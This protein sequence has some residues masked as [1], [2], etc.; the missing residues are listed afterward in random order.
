MLSRPW[1]VCSDAG[2]FGM[3]PPHGSG[4]DIKCC[5][6]QHTPP[7]PP[8]YPIHPNHTPTY[9]PQPPPHITDT[10]THH[11]PPHPLHTYT[12]HTHRPPYTLPP[13][14]PQP[15]TTRNTHTHTH[16]P[17][18]TCLFSP[19]TFRVLLRIQDAWVQVLPQPC[20]PCHQ[21]SSLPS[22]HLLPQMNTPSGP[23]Q[24]G[25]HGLSED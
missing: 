20:Y 19:S 11:T 21:A 7:C 24:Y 22:P 15:P 5:E 1:G 12:H 23:Q 8:Q 9:V 4:C 13:H 18:T 25:P 14:P 6:G 2:A 3:I 17:F 10:Y 16:T